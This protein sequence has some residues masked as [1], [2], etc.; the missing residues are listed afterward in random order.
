MN[1][2]TVNQLTRKSLTHQQTA[3]RCYK[4]FVLLQTKS[5]CCVASQRKKKLQANLSINQPINQSCII[6]HKWNLQL[7]VYYIDWSMWQSLLQVVIIFYHIPLL[8]TSHF[9]V[10]YILFL[11]FTHQRR[12]EQYRNELILTIL[13]ET[14]SKKVQ[15]MDRPIT[16]QWNNNLNF[17]LTV[18]PK[19]KNKK[20]R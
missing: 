18:T 15:S 8:H 14:A 7:H 11:R 5:F 19:K 3:F 1:I 9:H 16:R 6:T 17:F 4:R 2:L 20:G 10:T 13:S 12:I